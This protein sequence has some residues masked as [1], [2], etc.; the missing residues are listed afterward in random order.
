MHWMT[1]ELGNYISFLPSVLII[2]SWNWAS[3]RWLLTIGL[4][5]LT[6]PFLLHFIGNPI[7]TPGYGGYEPVISGLLWLVGVV[8]FCLGALGKV[9]R[10]RMDD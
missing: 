3:F 2:A 6:Y 4:G 5:L 8:I 10:F 1:W 9:L 7:E